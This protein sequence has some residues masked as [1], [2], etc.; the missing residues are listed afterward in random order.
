MRRGD[1]AKKAN[2]RVPASPS[3]RVFCFEHARSSYLD[4]EDEKRSLQGA[5]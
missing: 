3:L 4:R 1:A 5:D 2:P